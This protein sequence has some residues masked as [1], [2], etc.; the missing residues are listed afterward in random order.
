[1]ANRD[2]EY[3]EIFLA[4]ALDNFEEVNRLMTH[5]EKHSTDKETIHALFRI[6]HTLKGNASGMGFNGI[7]E[8]SHVLEDLFGEIREGRILVD[9]TLFS[10]LYKAV[11]VLGNLI[12]AIRDRR[13]PAIS[14]RQT[15]CVCVR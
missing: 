6:T 7:A 3:K 5:L 4:E 14:S 11:D 15:F 2:D 1:M 10:M 9:E 12:R 13:T 8:I